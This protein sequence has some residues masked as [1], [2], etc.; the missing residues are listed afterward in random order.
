MIGSLLYRKIDDKIPNTENVQF[1]M[2]MVRS[3]LSFF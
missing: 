1:N 3:L 2:K